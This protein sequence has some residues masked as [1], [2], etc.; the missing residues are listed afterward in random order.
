MEIN[1]KVVP[2]SHSSSVAKLD[3]GSYKIRVDASAVKG[4]ANDRLI[5]ML[6]V[7]FGVPK[8]SIRIIRG[9]KSRNKVVYV[10]N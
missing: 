9:A 8:S 5:E 7:H 10:G 6:S 4:K 1:V 3:D 2:N